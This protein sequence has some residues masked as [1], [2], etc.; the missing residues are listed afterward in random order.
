MQIIHGSSAPLADFIFAAI[1]NTQDVFGEVCHHTEEGDDPHPEDC[2]R[3]AGDD[4]SR[5]TRDITGTDRCSQCCAKTLELADGLVLFCSVGRDMPVCKNGADSLGKPVS[6]VRDLEKSGQK[7]HQNTGTDQKDQ[8]GKPPYKSVYR[9]VDVCDLFNG[10][11][12][13]HTVSCR[14]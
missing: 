8:H 11:D 7:S 1:V 3:S 10:S 14:Q 9:T 13:C 6:D 2:A 12:G 5:D 4:S